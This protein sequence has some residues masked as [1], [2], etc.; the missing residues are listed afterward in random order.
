MKTALQWT[1]SGILF[2]AILTGWGCTTTLSGD[3][4]SSYNWGSSGVYGHTYS[5]PT[6]TPSS[7]SLGGGYALNSLYYTGT[8]P[9]FYNNTPFDNYTYNRSFENYYYPHYQ[10]STG[11]YYYPSAY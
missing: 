2:C 7:L 9:H 8:Y 10:F 6:N 1:K 4:Q 11:K 5:Y 3:T